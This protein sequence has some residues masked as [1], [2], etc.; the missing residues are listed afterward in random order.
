MKA[1]DYIAKYLEAK[2]VK[3]VFEL[4]GG[5]ITHILDSISLKTSIKIITV[6]HEQSASFAADAYGRITGVPGVALA[7]SGPGATN[8]LTGIGSCYFD[9]SPAVF[10]TGQVNRHE[11]KG[12]RN[13]RQLG[14]QETDIIAMAR[15]ITKACFKVENGDDIP[16]TLISAFK[17]ATEGRP[18]PVL[19]DIPMDLQRVAL[20]DEIILENGTPSTGKLPPVDKNQL[21][22]LTADIQK[23]KRP[24]L[25]VGRGVKAAFA[26]VE[27]LKFIEKTNLPVVSSLLALDAVPYNLPARVGFIGSYGNRWANIALGECDLLIVAG[28]RLDIRQTGADTKYFE[29]RLI[30]HIDCEEGEINNRVKGCIPILA[31]VKQFFNAFISHNQTTSFQAPVEWN[32]YIAA[33]KQ[34]WPDTKEVTTPGIN[35]NL[36]MHLLSGL[37]QETSAYLTDVG[38]HQMWAAQSLELSAGQSFLTSAGMGAMGFGL[39]AAIGASFAANKAPVVLISGDGSLQINIQE[40]QTLFRNELPVKII[41]MNNR[42]LGMIRQFQDSYFESRYQSTFWGYSAPDFAKVAEAY[43]ISA[44]TITEESE[45][46]DAVKWL[47]EGE[48]NGK[49]VLLQVMIDPHTNTYPKL[50]FGKPITEMEP[51][52]KPIDMEGT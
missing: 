29:N 18:G 42:N 24:L 51:F 7:T 41:V 33:L 28:S 31:D 48:N 32:G 27:L 12:D 25:L 36:F 17:I 11:Q 15:P 5:M 13:I 46:N 52:S 35:P 45:I 9:S 22:K 2:N 4:S 19:I 34:K 23:A 50:A 43:N 14:F 10:I 44:K 20:P 1:S 47:W 39:P 30:Y 21:S 16:A 3:H 8:L 49:P 6:H 37:S 38:C 40:L 26:D